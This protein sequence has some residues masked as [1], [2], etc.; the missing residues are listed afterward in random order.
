M[1]IDHLGPAI[2]E[3]LVESGL[4]NNFSDLY[5]LDH[6]SL[7]KLERMADKSARNLV[8]AIQKSKSSG[9]SRLLH[10]LGVRHIGQRAGV[11]LARHFHSM[12]NLQNAKVEDLQ[13]V[14]EIGETVAKSLEAFFRLRSNS[15]EIARLKKLGVEMEVKGEIVG[16]ALLGKQFVLTGSLESLTRD[17]A[18][19]K[20]SALG[21]RVTSNVSIKT[22]YVVVGA[23]PGSK[24]EQ[25]RKIGIEIVSEK[26]FKKMLGLSKEK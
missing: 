6:S 19:I 20:I 1:D 3:Q 18:K 11:I 22:N 10:A 23:D 8:E 4:V 21:G 17:E 5:K 7:L 14:M 25:A 2:A 15:E 13:F 26:V 16:D 9:L 12:S 24:A